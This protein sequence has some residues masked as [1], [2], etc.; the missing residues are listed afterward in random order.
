MIL[1]YLVTMEIDDDKWNEIHIPG[2][3]EVLFREE[4]QSNL[5]SLP[6]P[7][8]VIVVALRPEHPRGK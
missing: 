6:E 4:I 7:M 2:T 8:N 3:A 5:E 1:Q